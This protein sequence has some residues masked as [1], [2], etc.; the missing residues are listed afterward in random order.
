M[1][2][3]LWIVLGLL[4]LLFLLP[5]ILGGTWNHFK[6]RWA[7]EI[8]ISEVRTLCENES[9]TDFLSCACSQTQAWIRPLPP[10][11]FQPGSTLFRVLEQ[12]FGHSDEL[13]WA[14]GRIIAPDVSKLRWV[15]LAGHRHTLLEVQIGEEWVLVDPTTGLGCAPELRM[16]A[17]ALAEQFERLP[18]PTSQYPFLIQ[19]SNQSNEVKK[20]PFETST[21]IFR[22]AFQTYSRLPS[23]YHRV[24]TAVFS[25][26]THFVIK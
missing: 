22:F 8:W 4:L 2:R 18:L 23:A 19:L 21:G 25:P 9:E 6:T 15:H 17:R 5:Y 14:L 11:P 10:T 12:G 13:A 7:E 26:E 24:W 20:A 3:T 16:G 1:K